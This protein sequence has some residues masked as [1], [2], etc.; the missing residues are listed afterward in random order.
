[1]IRK[2]FAS[3]LVA[4]SVIAGCGGPKDPGTVK[5]KKIS[6]LSEH[7]TRGIC[8]HNVKAYRDG[9]PRQDWN[10]QFCAGLEMLAILAT[11]KLMAVHDKKVTR[12]ECAFKVAGCDVPVA[13]EIPEPE[14]DCL[15]LRVEK[16]L[17][18]HATV[19]EL[20]ACIQE[21]IERTK[22][23]N[24]IVKDKTLCDAEDR[25]KAV[26]VLSGPACSHMKEAC[27]E[28]LLGLP[29]RIGSVN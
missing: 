7:D 23:V 27:P 25:I 24:V 13:H 22:Q 19:A 15:R 20:Q 16:R 14:E 2:S 1:M 18:C 29:G 3:S 10:L 11:D 9:V 6:E 17:S 4:L 28:F 5:D 21:R 8:A 26:D 12:D